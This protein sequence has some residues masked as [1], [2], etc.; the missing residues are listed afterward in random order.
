MLRMGALRKR[1]AKE[2][3]E[4][5]NAGGDN[6]HV[7]LDPTPSDIVTMEEGPLTAPK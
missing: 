5:G 7:L 6:D 1:D 4:S 3:T 2:G